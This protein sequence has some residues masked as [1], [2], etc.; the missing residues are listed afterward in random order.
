MAGQPFDSSNGEAMPAICRIL[1][2]RG[3]LGFWGIKTPGSGGVVQ[4][5]VPSGAGSASVLSIWRSGWAWQ[6]WPGDQ[7]KCVT[8]HCFLR[9]EWSLGG[10]CRSEAGTVVPG[11]LAPNPCNLVGSHVGFLPIQCEQMCGI[12]DT[13]TSKSSGTFLRLFSPM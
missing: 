9:E 10:D 5:H 12:P 4:H 2:S 8:S 3:E 1:L 11:P 6:R 13:E 7:H